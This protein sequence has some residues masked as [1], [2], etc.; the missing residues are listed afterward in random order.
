M[1]SSQEITEKYKLP[2]FRSRQIVEAIYKKGIKDF[3]DMTSLPKNLREDLT[4]NEKIYSLDPITIQSSPSSQTEKVLFFLHDN[5]KIETVLMNYADGRH[6]VCVSSQAGCQLGCKFCATG[7][8]KFGRNLTYQEI[9]DQILFFHQK[10]IRQ[11]DHL[12]NI[13]YMGMGEPFM[14][15]ENVI[16]SIKYLNNED[17]FNLGARRITISTAGVCDGIDKLSLEPLQVNLA[18]SLHAPNQQIREKIMPI[19]RRFNLET[20]MKS[21][22][23]YLE[24]TNRRVSYEYVMLKDI[25]DSPENAG[26]LAKLIKNQLCHVNLIPYNKTDHPDIDQSNREKIQNFKNILTDLGINA[27]IRMT[28]GQDID[29]A[30][31]QLANKSLNINK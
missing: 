10:L 3:S 16:T 15:Y 25:N 11:N 13:V 9:C 28:M 31:G 7:M 20:L 26:E 18:I 30:C 2:A 21:V 17:Y 24:K 8:L 5:Q 14:N 29:A 22:E 1:I 23:N 6:T 4:K 27:T 19:A 12:T